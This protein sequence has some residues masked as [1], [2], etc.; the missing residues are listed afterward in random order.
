MI[1]RWG[2][3]RSG[4]RP[5]GWAGGL[6]AMAVLGLVAPGARVWAVIFL[7]TADPAY[8]T[9]APTGSLTNSGWQMQGEW[10]SFLG[11]PVAPHFFLTAKHVGGAV[12]GTFWLNGA[13]HVTTA[14]FPA[15]DCDLAVWRVCGAFPVFAPLYTN[16]DE[17]GKGLVVI[18][19]GTQRGLPVTTAGPFGTRTNGWRWGAFD[20]TRRWGE[21]QVTAI[22]DGGEGGEQLKAE[23]N[24][25]GGANESQLSVGDSGGAVFLREG[26]TWK[27]AG[28]NYSVDGPYSNTNS[29]DGAFDA[30]LF[31]Q[32][33]LYQ[34]D[35]T[36][37]VWFPSGPRDQPGA[38]YAT[39]VSSHLD[40]INTILSMPV[41]DAERLVLQSAASAAGPYEDDPTGTADE[42]MRTI[43]V[44]RPAQ[45]RFYRLRC[46]QALSFQ[47][48][49]A[50]GDM[51]V[52][53]YR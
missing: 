2:Q 43:R 45:P 47:S 40:W 14:C 41:P 53:E 46:C 21:N 34:F 20:S 36:N 48:I 16:R 24:G 5:G 31:D 29:G 15:S 6:P 27:L 19:R 28:I 8:N 30:A 7:S 26:S 44:A 50:D 10:G 42:M 3:L 11:T 37:W 39:R 35:G 23:F 52:L 18:G 49:Q 4:R 13:P 17:V 12:G 1:H 38:F 9:S 33:D 51:L 22:A 32:G 25:D